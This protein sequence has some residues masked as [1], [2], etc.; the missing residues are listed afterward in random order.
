MKKC[1]LFKFQSNKAQISFE[2]IIV[3]AVVALIVSAILIDFSKQANDTFILTNTKAITL[4][5]LNKLNIEN[6]LDCYLKSMS[7]NAN[8]ITIDVEGTSCSLSA[9]LIADEVEKE[10]CKLQPNSDDEINCG[11]NYKLKII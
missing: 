4:N 6:N 3:L 5:E 1:R 10:Y 7:F 8:Q 11:E 9:S 2:L